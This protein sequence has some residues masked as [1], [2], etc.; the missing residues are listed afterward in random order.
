VV[1]NRKTPDAFI[2]RHSAELKQMH[3]LMSNE[4]GA[5]AAVSWHTAKPQIFLY[6][7]EG[8]A[9]YGLNYPDAQYRRVTLDNVGQWIID[10]RKAGSVGVIMRVKGEGEDHELERLPSDAKRYEQGGLVILVY[11]QTPS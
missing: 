5:A 7:T 2:A 11:A 4:L 9:N 6:N 10:A 8:E 3:T 1:V